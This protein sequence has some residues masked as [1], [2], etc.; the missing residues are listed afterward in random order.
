MDRMRSAGSDGQAEGMKM[1]REILDQCIHLVSGVYVMPS[2]DR[3]EPA[4]ELVRSIRDLF[5]IRQAVA[6]S[7]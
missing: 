7:S 2:F 1:A 5:E 6:T 4:A 3:Y